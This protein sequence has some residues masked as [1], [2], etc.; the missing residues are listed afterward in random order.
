MTGPGT[1]STKLRAVVFDMGGVLTTDPFAGM[2]DYARELGIPDDAIADEV[3][4]GARF[5]A[6]ETGGSTMRDFLKWLCGSIEEQFGVRVEIRRLAASLES[7][8]EVRP[9]MTALLGELHAQGLRLGLLTNNVREARSWWESGVLPLDRFEVVLDSSE[10]GVRKPDPRVYEIA[11]ERLGLDAAEVAFV[12]DL[13]A[14]VDG[15]LQ[16]GLRGLLFQDPSQCRSELSAAI[17]E[18]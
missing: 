10:L 16:V 4:S 3:R 5:K 15:A 17:N 14:N 1:G 8:Q 11:L 12:D 2:V 9:E 13:Q 6:V 7:G 18:T